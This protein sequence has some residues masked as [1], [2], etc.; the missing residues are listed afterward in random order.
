M[1]NVWSVVLVGSGV[2][3]TDV[4]PAISLA[5]LSLR[6]DRVEGERGVRALTAREH[7]RDQQRDREPSAHGAPV[8]SLHPASLGAVGRERERRVSCDRR[9][10]GS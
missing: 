9:G 1:S 8:G 5:R 7:E 4:V 10:A 6:R 2:T 3:G